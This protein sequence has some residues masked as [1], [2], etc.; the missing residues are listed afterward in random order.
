MDASTWRQ[1][2]A[3]IPTRMLLLCEW[4]TRLLAAVAWPV[5]EFRSLIADELDRRGAR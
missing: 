4:L 1:W 5:E 2:F 3:R